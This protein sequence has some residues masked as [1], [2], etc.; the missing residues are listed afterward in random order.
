MISALANTIFQRAIADYHV[1]NEIDQV[2]QNP[3]E[4]SSLEHLL[5]M[6]CWID[7]VQWHM[8]DVV[9][10]PEIDPKVGLYWKRRIDESNQHRTDTVEY[11]DS[12]YLLKFQ[13]ITPNED[14]KINTESPAWAMDRLSILALKIYHMNEEATRAEATAEHR[15]KCQEKLN[16]LLDQKSDMFISIGQLIEEFE[17]GDKFM[18]VYKQMKMYNDEDL[19]PVLYQNKK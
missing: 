17:S 12:Y 14:A 16:V 15:A 8:E 19:N 18:K 10:N 9:R 5:Y 2:I 7:T 4:S 6:K 11:I 13:H 1:E 3:F